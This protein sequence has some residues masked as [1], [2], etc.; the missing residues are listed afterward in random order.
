MIC[1]THG[2]VNYKE[3][4]PVH[5][6]RDIFENGDFS[7]PYLKNSASTHSV[8]ELYLPVEKGRYE[9]I[10]HNERI[11]S[12]CKSNKI[13]DENH[14][15]LVCKA[16]SQIRDIFFSKIETKIPNFKLLSHDTLISILNFIYLAML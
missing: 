12:F 2:Y 3:K 16:D 8:F 14:F 6:Y 1:T 5:T 9:K 10:P 7:P 15:L 11:C 4:G 13:E